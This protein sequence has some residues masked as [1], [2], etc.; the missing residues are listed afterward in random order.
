VATDEQVAVG[1][2]GQAGGVHQ[3]AAAAR[4]EGPDEGAGRTVVLQHTGVGVDDEQ[5][6][7]GA[8]HHVLGADQPAAAVRDEGLD[9]GPRPAVVLLHFMVVADEQ[10]AVGAELQVGG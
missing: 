6:A 3:P 5:V 7:V 8:E 4:D 9:E 10:V 1:A 2:E